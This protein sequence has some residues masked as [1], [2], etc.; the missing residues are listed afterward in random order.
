VLSLGKLKKGGKILDK[1]NVA[2]PVKL[3]RRLWEKAIRLG[4]SIGHIVEKL[5]T[6]ALEDSKKKK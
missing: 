3:H 2:I 4:V 6:D 1:K 5:L